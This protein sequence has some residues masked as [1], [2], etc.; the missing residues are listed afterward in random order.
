MP[1]VSKLQL[2]PELSAIITNKKYLAVLFSIL[3]TSYLVKTF[4]CAFVVPK[5]LSHIPKV[6][7][8][9]WFWSVLTG[10]SNDTRIKK[11]MLPMMNEHGLCL[12]YIMGRWVLTVGD[13]IL[14]QQLLKDV[15]T[16]PKEQITM[17]P[18]S[19]CWQHILC[20]YVYVK[21]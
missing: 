14:L 11:L 6:N 10:E 15:E 12:K 18:V 2:S 19:W 7:T 21:L 1:T 8:V 17:S 16:Y 3:S 13:P 9:G 4:W 20:Y 5:E